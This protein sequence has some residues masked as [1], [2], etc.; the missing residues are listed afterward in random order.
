[1]RRLSPVMLFYSLLLLSSASFAQSGNVSVA[2]ANG[3]KLR[4]SFDS[5]DGPATF[6]GIDSYATDES[7][8]GH[9]IIADNVIDTDGNTHEV[10]YIGGSISN[11]NKIISIVF[12]PMIII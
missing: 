7:K 3:N 8:A 12:I 6:T 4:Y 10:N 11:R 5:A 1:M 9:I 2:D